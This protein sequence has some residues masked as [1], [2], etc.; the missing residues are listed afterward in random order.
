MARRS[1]RYHQRFVADLAARVGWLRR[2]R[3]PEQ[4][5]NLR[6]A[7]GRF[8][9]RVAAYP[10]LGREIER[11]RGVAY[12]V[13]PIGHRLPYLVWY[14]YDTDDPDGPVSLLMLMHEAQDRERFDPE[15]FE[16]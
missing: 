3:P 12:C 9:E 1:L 5:R 6:E 8:R 2:H 10:A 14:A 7:L 16:R 4:R 13:R 11:R 15:V